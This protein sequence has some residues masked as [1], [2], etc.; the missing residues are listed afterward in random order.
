MLCSVAGAPRL[1]RRRGNVTISE[2]LFGGRNQIPLIYMYT[3]E[4]LYSILS[5]PIYAPL[6]G[7]LQGSGLLFAY[8]VQCLTRFLSY[9]NGAF[10]GMDSTI[11]FFF[12]F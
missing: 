6:E 5:G 1:P 11:F 2:Y 10:P 9:C 4:D 3:L 12:L 8:L 7:I